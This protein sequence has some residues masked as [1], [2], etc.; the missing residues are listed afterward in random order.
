[1][2]TEVD[3]NAEEFNV[4]HPGS[5]TLAETCRAIKTKQL[6]RTS[7]LTN[8][9]PVI[10]ERTDG[11]RVKVNI[12]TYKIADSILDVLDDIKCFDVSTARGAANAAAEQD[13]FK[14]VWSGEIWVQNKLTE[15]QILGRTSP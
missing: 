11:T 2:S 8:L 5:P 6:N 4:N 1:M 15:I 10:N 12:G 9:E 13:E 14:P 3:L 7:N